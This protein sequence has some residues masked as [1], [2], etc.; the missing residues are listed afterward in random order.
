MSMTEFGDWLYA[1]PVS[2][3]LRETSW[4]IPNVQS[5]HIIAIAVVVGSALV[6]EL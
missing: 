3:A 5:V 4:I 2:T 6:D 1:T